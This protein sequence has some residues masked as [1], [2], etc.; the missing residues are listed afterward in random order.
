ME[1]R[2]VRNVQQEFFCKSAQ[3]W[4]NL[5]SDQQVAVELLLQELFTQSIQK[6]SI[7]QKEDDNVKSK[8]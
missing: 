8:N 4:E 3:Q 2:I 5:S 6:R 1:R 7:N